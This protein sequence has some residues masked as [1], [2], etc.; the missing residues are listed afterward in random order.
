MDEERF[1]IEAAAHHAQVRGGPSRIWDRT[2]PGRPDQIRHARQCLAE[3]LDGCPVADDAVLCLSELAS[4]SVIHSDSGKPGG[5]FT[6]RTEIRDGEYVRLEVHDGGGRWLG[7]RHT[8]GR[9]HGLAIVRDVAADS[10][11]GG[12]ALTGW[13]AWARLDWRPAGAAMTGAHMASAPIQGLQ[14]LAAELTR[15]HTSTAWISAGAR[16]GELMLVQG[17]AIGYATGFFWWRTGRFSQGRPL[18][19]IHAAHDPAGAARRIS[20]LQ[21]PPA[22][23]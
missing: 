5:A 13:I 10:G 8:D 7:R 11:V 21:T 9:A 6:V 22:E 1:V 3:M 19:T 4:N 12:D 17:Q 15:C 2:F 18:Y 20:H 14:A 16:E 23:Q